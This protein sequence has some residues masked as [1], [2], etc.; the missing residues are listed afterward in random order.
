MSISF[1]VL[2]QDKNT[3]A[4]A[5]KI[6]TSHGIINTPVFMPVA[7]R[8]A[9]KTLAADELLDIGVEIVLGNT[10]HLYMRPGI[11]VIENA[12]G[13]HKF[14]QWEKPILTDSGGFQIFS[15]SE[16]CKVKDAGVEFRSVYDGSTH[17][18]SP[19]KAIEMQQK[20]GADIIMVLDEC[21]PYPARR[22]RVLDAVER[23]LQWATRCRDSFNEDENALF[24]IVQGGTYPDLR[25]RSAKETAA[26]D[27]SGYGIGGFSV[28]EP[29]EMMFDVLGKTL[30]N[31][32]LEK[33][34]YLMGVGNP[35]SLLE[36]I[37]MGID[38]FDCAL[39]TRMARNGT[40]F[41]S[42]GRLNIRNLQYKLDLKA[43]DPRC[44]CYTCI[45]FSRSYLRHLFMLGEILAHRLLTIHNLAFVTNLMTEA[46]EAILNDV[47]VDFQRA[48][49]EKVD[50]E[51]SERG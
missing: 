7:T 26:L 27:F 13:L 6:Y 31:L 3:D 42:S 48:F 46:R 14:M 39:P 18:F 34:R 28:G 33:P 24:G 47:F 37:K 11:E 1:E 29:H 4:R 25:E 32:P 49:N 44:N 23:S 10:Y 51:V 15:L 35:T 20:L 19:E 8:G 17:F 38:M 2:H 50:F 5:G 9:V 41:T 30:K 40:L 21:P 36:V 16:T 43:L 12:G 45:N 22:T